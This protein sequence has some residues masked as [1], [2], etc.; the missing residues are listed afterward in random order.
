V[1]ADPVDLNLVLKDVLEMTKMNKTLRQDVEIVVDMKSQQIIPGNRDK[2]KQAF[3][4]IVINAVQAMQGVAQPRLE[5]RTLDK[6]DS[7]RSL[8]VVEI[9]DYGC[10]MDEVGL[11]RIFEPFH[12]TKDKG[13]GLGLAITHKIIES[14]MGRISVESSK[15]V[16]TTFILEFPLREQ[17]VD[18]LSLADS[19]RANEDFS[20]AFRGQKRSGNG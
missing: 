5:I 2:L 10:G 4:N 11:R 12:T 15:G 9:Q 20:K 7:G 17:G 14:H 19:Q 16:G 1:K 13:T 3:L 6:A 8:V 18:K